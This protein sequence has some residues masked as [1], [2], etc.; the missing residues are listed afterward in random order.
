MGSDPV[1]YITLDRSDPNFHRY[2][3]GQLP[4]NE[5]AIPVRSLHVNSGQ[6]TV[7]FQI[8]SRESILRPSIWIVAMQVMRLDLIALSL[9]PAVC[10][11]AYAVAKGLNPPNLGLALL[12]LFFLHG[13]VFCRNDYCDHLSGVDRVNEKGGSRVIQNG[14][15]SAAAVQRIY[16]VFL[17]VAVGFAT[18][19]LLRDPSLSWLAVIG[20]GLGILGYTA[21][22][23]GRFGW[24]A[25]DLALFLASGPLLTLGA[26]RVAGLPLRPLVAIAAGKGFGLLAVAYIEIRHMIS[27]V[28]DD[29]ADIRTLPVRIGFD[30]AKIVV[31][32]LYILSAAALIF[33]FWAVKWPYGLFLASAYGFFMIAM[34]LRVCRANSP[35]SSLLSSLLKET[36]AAQAL[37]GVIFLSGAFL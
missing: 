12:A 29:T 5:I 10:V 26:D 33:N 14:W 27:M 36:L 16:R 13:A 15:I 19:I 6:E 32:A 2:L 25:G 20:G 1:K 23:R 8:I 35:L 22:K 4:G 30:R 17:F 7:T 31:A 24:W 34:A 28:V 18:P 37:Y 21:L 3:L 11:F 9:L